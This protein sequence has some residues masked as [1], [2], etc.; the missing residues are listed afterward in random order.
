MMNKFNITIMACFMLAILIVATVNTTVSAYGERKIED[1]YQTHLSGYT[2]TIYSD[3]DDSIKLRREGNFIALDTDDFDDEFNTVDVYIDGGYALIGGNRGIYKVSVAEKNM[4]IE[5]IKSTHAP[6]RDITFNQDT[7]RAIICGDDES[8]YLYKPVGDGE[9]IFI[10]LGSGNRLNPNSALIE[11]GPKRLKHFYAA[12]WKDADTAYI[13]GEDRSMVKYYVPDDKFTILSNQMSSYT[14]TSVFTDIKEPALAWYEAY[15][16]GIYSYAEEFDAITF[17][18]VVSLCAVAGAIIIGAVGGIASGGVLTPL[19]LL[20][21]FALGAAI[22]LFFATLSWMIGDSYIDTSVTFEGYLFG[23]YSPPDTPLQAL[24]WS[25]RDINSKTDAQ[26]AAEIQK[27]NV[28]LDENEEMQKVMDDLLETIDQPSILDMVYEWKNTQYMLDVDLT[29]IEFING[30]NAIIVGEGGTI[31]GYNPDIST[32]MYPN[33]VAT[34]TMKLN[35]NDRSLRDVSIHKDAYAIAVGDKGTEYTLGIGSGVVNIKKPVTENNI[36]AY[37]ESVGNILGVAVGNNGL[38]IQATGS[39]FVQEKKSN[40]MVNWQDI[41]FYNGYEGIAVGDDVVAK[42]QSTEFVL[43]GTYVSDEFEYDH[44]IG[45]VELT[46]AETVPE[47][48]SVTAY[49]TNDNKTWTQLVGGEVDYLTTTPNF[50]YKNW[51]QFR[52]KFELTGNGYVTPSITSIVATVYTY[53]IPDLTIKVDADLQTIISLQELIFSLEARSDEALIGDDWQFDW[54]FGDPNADSADGNH[55]QVSGTTNTQHTYMYPG[56]YNASVAVTVPEYEGGFTFIIEES[57]NIHN[58]DPIALISYMA[59]GVEYILQTKMDVLAEIEYTFYSISS[60]DNDLYPGNSL[61]YVWDWGDGFT[62]STTATSATH[63][64]SAVG[65]FIMR[66]YVYDGGG[67]GGHEPA[68]GQ[69]I[70]YIS[71]REGNL[72]PLVKILPQEHAEAVGLDYWLQIGTTVTFTCTAVDDPAEGI[73]RDNIDKYIWEI[74]LKG[75][76]ITTLSGESPSWEPLLVGKYAIQLEVWDDD[77]NYIGEAPEPRAG[78]DNATMLVQWAPLNG[79]WV[80]DNYQFVDGWEVPGAAGDVG[81]FEGSITILNGG[82]LTFSRT[83]MIMGTSANDEYRIVVMAGGKFSITNGSIVDSMLAVANQEYEGHQPMKR[84]FYYSFLV[85]GTLEIVGSYIGHVGR[86]GPQSSWN[87]IDGIQVGRSSTNKYWPTVTLDRAVI[88]YAQSHGIT[89]ERGKLTI[90]DSSFYQ[91]K[92]SQENILTGTAVYIEAHLDAGVIIRGCDGDET[93]ILKNGAS[94]KSGFVD[95]DIHLRISGRKIT[96]K[97]NLFDISSSAAILVAEGTPLIQNNIISQYGLIAIDVQKNANPTVVDNYLDGQFGISIG[98]YSAASITWLN[99]TVIE[100]NYAL[101]SASSGIVISQDTRITNDK[102]FN[103]NTNEC[104]SITGQTQIYHW[105]KVYVQ[106]DGKTAKGAR[107]RVYVDDEPVFDDRTDA[108]G[109][110]PYIQIIY[111][112]YGLIGDE[113]I[114]NT[115]VKVRVDYRGLSTANMTVDMFRSKDLVV[116][117]SSAPDDPTG[118]G[119]SGGSSD[120]DADSNWFFDLVGIDSWYLIFLLI[121]ILAAAGGLSYYAFAIMKN[122]KLGFYILVAGAVVMALTLSI[123][124]DS[125]WAWIVLWSLGTAVVTVLILIELK[126]IP[127]D[128]LLRIK[129][130]IPKR[131]KSSAGG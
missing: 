120:S 92:D 103:E 34:P 89:F 35:N 121:A 68:N 16:V 67:L 83:K 116:K 44:N 101:Y 12:A 50:I 86:G 42:Y 123:L 28:I 66:L 106:S 78:T 72:A 55:N 9:V 104:R 119:A 54:D 99:N 49:V 1:E 29:D 88:A 65:A 22:G 10:G 23:R 111:G 90:L 45:K 33:G 41:K 108:G 24:A 19:L 75:L 109:L 38:F 93:I 25:Q 125:H 85:Y 97:D 4:N 61:S 8:V 102:G 98:L 58:R 46:W 76:L 11:I 87:G 43:S 114:E 130:M 36:N 30:T 56:I 95:N 94:F 118:S 52:Y 110:T 122:P 131:K 77:V 51:K 74:R 60:V 100:S 32:D 105:L 7:G 91:I 63:T 117:L 129:R 112:T 70:I 124:K 57:L 14:V 113:T 47:G 17:W 21:G 48:C 96:I 40:I 107:V 64:Y 128:F 71:A 39:N 59:D 15:N 18:S 37:D 115:V 27:I 13:V 127:S 126:V 82:H 73:Y 81:I 6:V 3:E 84:Y 79:N 53:S 26:W 62:D 5:F 80:V 69:K 2:D 20:L 31:F